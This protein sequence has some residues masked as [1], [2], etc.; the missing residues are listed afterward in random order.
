MLKQTLT[1]A[2]TT[3]DEQESNRYMLISVSWSCYT[4][5]GT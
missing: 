1:Q 3:P 5:G 4:V 2:S